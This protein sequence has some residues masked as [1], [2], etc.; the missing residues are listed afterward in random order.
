MYSTA[1]ALVFL[2]VA[3]AA[4]G[5]GRVRANDRGG[6][7]QANGK[8]LYLA[9][10]CFGCHGRV[11]QGGTLNYPTPALAQIQLPLD[12]FIAFLRGASKDM[13]SF[14]ADVLSDKDAAD[15]HAYLRSLSGHRSTSDFP[16]L[17]Q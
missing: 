13:P 12:S 16:L 15:I 2:T 7:D 8:R 3:L 4:A 17:N 14:S 1:A 11:G 9:D 5:N 6:G 10:G